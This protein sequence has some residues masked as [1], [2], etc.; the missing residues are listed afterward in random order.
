MKRIFAVL[1]I[2]S[3]LLGGCIKVDPMGSTGGL[4]TDNTASTGH[5]SATEET[6]TSTDAPPATAPVE[7]EPAASFGTEPQTEPTELVT[8]PAEMPT[9]EPTEPET[10]PTEPETEPTGAVETVPRPDGSYLVVIDA[11]HQ[12]KGNN[13]LEPNGP[14]SDD[15]KKKASYGTASDF[16]DF[17]E[18]ELNLIVALLLQQELE[19][20]GY[21]VI[22]TRTTHD[23]DISNVQRAQIANE[24]QA[25]A[26]IRLH[27]NGSDDQ[28]AH[29]AFTICQ[30][31]DNAYQP[32]LYEINRCLAEHI[33]NAYVAATG[34]YDRGV[35]ETNTMTGIN[36]CEVP[37]CIIE[38]GYMS[39]REEDAKMAT[40]EYQARMAK[41]IADGLDSYFAAL[42]D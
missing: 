9:E 30:R 2:I 8:E 33:I 28:E 32:Q 20:R 7:T 12:R 36:W 16:I 14:G 15:M 13:D 18:Y 31:S 19:S 11:G 1:L 27:A 34:C 3:V 26:F 22:M 10:E 23:V 17:D 24:A 38:M 37:N 40:A 5:T 4:P 39:N 42:E 41:G 29:G 25:D 35:W 21:T 6:A